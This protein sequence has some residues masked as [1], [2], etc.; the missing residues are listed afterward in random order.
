MLSDTHTPKHTRVESSPTMALPST[1]DGLNFGQ[2]RAKVHMKTLLV[3]IDTKATLLQRS[4][5]SRHAV[6]LQTDK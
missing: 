4:H 6:E 1:K 2:E 5:L 3:T